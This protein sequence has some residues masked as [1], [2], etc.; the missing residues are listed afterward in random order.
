M[1]GLRMRCGPIP[2]PIPLSTRA[3]TSFEAG[4]GMTAR[5]VSAVARATGTCQPAAAA[6]AQGTAITLFRVAK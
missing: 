6:W 1:N 3:I 4:A 2:A 5:P